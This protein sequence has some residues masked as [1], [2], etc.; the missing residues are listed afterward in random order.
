MKQFN[1]DCLTVTCIKC[2][3]NSRMLI[4]NI[5]DPKQEFKKIQF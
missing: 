1:I 3:N 5:L 2:I 4:K